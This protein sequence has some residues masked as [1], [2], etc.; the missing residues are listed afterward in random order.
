MIERDARE[1]AVTDEVLQSFAGA[2]SA[3]YAQLMQSLVR[4][5]HAFARDV[6]L[7]GEEWQRGIDFLTRA[8]HI[9][10]DRR[11]EFILLSD[12]LG[13]SMLIVGINEPASAGATESTVLGPFFAADAPQIPL[14]GDIAFGAKGQP[15]HVAGTIRGTDG[16]PVPGA[17]VETWEADE[18]G[19]YDVQYAD[20]HTAGRGWL[21]SGPG[22]EYRFWA[23]H[24]APYP[25]PDDGPVGG[26][27]AAAGR[28]PMRPAHL[29]LKVEAPGYQTLITHIF[30]GGGA[31][32]DR[33]AVFGVKDSLVVE[34]TE[35]PPGPGP[36][37]RNLDGSWTSVQFDIV[38]APGL[39]EGSR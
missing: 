33:D 24:P 19:F 7:T 8:G 34:F 22:G 12:V 30:V 36:D 11:Q 21:R 38:L 25:I 32:L 35:Q 28:G 10:D 14:G 13:L 1:Q 5:L 16:A 18:D 31:Y 4:H 39:P 27:L 6:R 3:R 23:V 37:G 26:L 15:C 20:R 9:T 17:R 2:E 29:H